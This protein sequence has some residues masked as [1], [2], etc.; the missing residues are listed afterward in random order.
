M[1]HMFK[2]VILGTFAMSLSACGGDAQTIEREGEPDLIMNDASDP[3]M[4]AATQKARGSLD[5]FWTVLE[6]AEDT[7][8]FAIKAGLDTNDGSLEHIWIADLSRD[9]K[10][11]SGVLANQPYNIVGDPD[12]GDKV[13]FRTNQVTDWSYIEGEKMRG[14]YTTRVLMKNMPSNEAAQM[15]SILHERP[16]P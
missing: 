5:H 13:T 9:G 10:V 4:V 15:E 7:D 1:K 16:M 8:T 12:L 2:A 3:A 6:A 14:H 11:M